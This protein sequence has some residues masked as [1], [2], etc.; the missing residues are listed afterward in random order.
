MPTF[1]I[2][3]MT[4][5]RKPIILRDQAII[6]HMAIDYGAVRLSAV[7]L[8]INAKR[9]FKVAL[10]SYGRSR[11]ILTDREERQQ[12]LLSALSAYRALTGC[13]T[14]LVTASPGPDDTS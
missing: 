7:N 10:P 13:D 12:L 14:S 3:K 8:I 2:Q 9:E 4:A 6:A 1:T 11:V 5:L